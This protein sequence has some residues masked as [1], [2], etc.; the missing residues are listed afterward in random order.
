MDTDRSKG[1]PGSPGESARGSVGGAGGI[2]GVG[3]EGRVI[4]GAGGMGGAGGPGGSDPFR[5][6]SRT[7][8]VT[9]GFLIAGLV[10]ISV[11]VVLLKIDSLHKD[12]QIR[13]Q[14]KVI[15]AQSFQSHATLCA[16]RNNLSHRVPRAERALKR[17]EDFLADH[18]NGIP[19]IPVSLIKA[20]IDD[21]RDALNNLKRTVRSL[22]RH[23]ICKE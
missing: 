22:N 1:Q 20:G 11:F 17:S 4:G 13:N 6:L 19:G 18:P 14:A 12:Q 10:A 21:D 16:F 9:I 8:N 15:R 3:G 5:S 23:L 7:F 2:G